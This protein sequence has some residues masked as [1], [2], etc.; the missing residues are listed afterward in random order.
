MTEKKPVVRVAVVGC[1]HGELDIIYDRVRNHRGDPIDLLICCGDFQATRNLSDLK[2]MAVP[3]KYAAMC[4]FYKYY[5]GEKQAPVLTLFIG[6]NHEASNH[7]QEFPYGG[8]VAPNIYFMGYAGVVQFKGL[9]IGGLSG[10][11]KGHDYLTGHHEFPPYNESAKRSVYHV[12]NLEVFRLRQ[13][14]KA[15]DIM[16]SHDWPRGVYHYGDVQQLLR[17]K[18]FFA[19]EIERNELGS[20]PAADILFELCPRYWFSAHLHCKFM[21][22]V[23]HQTNTDSNEIKITQFLA[24]DKCLPNRQFFQVMEIPSSGSSDSQDLTYD[25]EWL[26]VLKNTNHLLSVKRHI[27]H[28]PGPGY[29]G[30]WNFTPTTEEL[31]EIEKIFCNDFQIPQNFERTVPPYDEKE[32][33][34]LYNVRPPRILFNP[35]TVCFCEKLGMTDPLQVIASSSPSKQFRRPGLSSSFVNE[36]ELNITQTE[37]SDLSGNVSMNPDEIALD[38][39]SD[40]EPVTS[41]DV[42]HSTPVAKSANQTLEIQYK[43]PL[44]YDELPKLK[45]NESSIGSSDPVVTSS[46]TDDNK[47]SCSSSFFLDVSGDSSTAVPTK[48]P[49]EPRSGGAKKFVRRNAAMYENSEDFLEAA[50]AAGL[51]EDMVSKAKQSRSEKKARKIMSK[52]GLKQ[53][54]SEEEEEV[55][56]TGVEEKDIDLVMSQANVSR[57]KAVRAL[58]NNNNDIVN[59]IMAAH[60][61]ARADVVGAIEVH[62]APTSH[63][64]EHRVAYA[65]AQGRAGSIRKQPGELLALENTACARAPYPLSHGDM[66]ILQRSSLFRRGFALLESGCVTKKNEVNILVKNL[67]DVVLGGLTYWAFGYGLQYGTGPWTNPF[68]AV[69]SF[70]LDSDDEDTMGITF[71]TFIFQV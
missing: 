45:T 61:A 35:Q 55:D 17:F 53:E 37:S 66:E 64:M 1:A 46:N 40:E 9:R 30:R 5:S 13:L 2:C 27:N 14:S 24:L 48:R 7:L 28:M 23:N 52:L 49:M 4:S 22:Q 43:S 16:I 44:S 54:E 59:A 15:P 10:I 47:D 50:A 12:R 33:V 39:D 36:E 25:P 38:D 34:N 19:Q 57:G 29:D 69:G 71:A 67:A 63:T 20:R 42:A 26:A 32:G 18:P 65:S 3:L 68:F 21:S 58:K 62:G 41:S 70:F 11:Y 6:G 60:R 51:S 31:E 56:E 8:W